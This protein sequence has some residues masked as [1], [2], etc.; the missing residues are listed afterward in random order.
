MG[1][2]ASRGLVRHGDAHVD[3]VLDVAHQFLDLAFEEVVG[4]FDGA[5]VDGDALLGLELVDQGL[6]VLDDLRLGPVL[7]DRAAEVGGGGGLPVGADAGVGLA[8]GRGTEI[9]P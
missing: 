4:P 7:G 6:D 1:P 8:A 3:V 5:L 9:S 2:I